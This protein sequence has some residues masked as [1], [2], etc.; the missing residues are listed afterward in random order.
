MRWPAHI[1]PNVVSDELVS[2]LDI[3]PTIAQASHAPVP[4]DLV[5]RSLLDPNRGAMPEL[6][7]EYSNSETHQYSVLTADGRWRLLSFY[8]LRGLSDL[9]ADPSGKT[10]EIERY[11]EVADA[12]T[13]NYLQWRKAMRNVTVEYDI[14]NSSGAATLTGNDMQRSPGYSGFTLAIGVTPS[15]EDSGTPGVIAEQAGRWRLE[16]NGSAG[17]RLEVLGRV[18][19][20]PALPVGQCSEVVVSSQFNFSPVN[21]RSN[22]A[23][24]DL[25]I[26]GIRAANNH[27]KEPALVTSGYEQPTYIGMNPAGEEL[28]RGELSRPIILNERVVPDEQGGEIGNG[29]S[30]VPAT[31]PAAD[32]R[33]VL[34]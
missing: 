31:C 3:F 20:A 13:D 1:A 27:W 14:L 5:G 16:S 22:K 9:N 25:Y 6:Y 34:L 21:S 12:L 24:I 15:S 4:D 30:G 17:L 29:I 7:W 11:P 8:G 23:H 26:N 32:T 2:I 28:F 10:N 19:K 33:T 18:L